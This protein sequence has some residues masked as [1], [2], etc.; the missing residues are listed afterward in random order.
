M[1]QFK[2]RVNLKSINGIKN[3]RENFLRLKPQPNFAHR[4][5][6]NFDFFRPHKNALF[7]SLIFST[8]YLHQL[9]P[10]LLS[11]FS[12]NYHYFMLNITLHWKIFLYE[13]EILYF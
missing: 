2:K 4:S 1:F 9:Q 8:I 11:H 5:Q 13:H 7:I 3:L 12:S 6:L 10:N